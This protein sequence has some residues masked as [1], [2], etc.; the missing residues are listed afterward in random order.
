MKLR[1]GGSRARQIHARADGWHGY[2]ATWPAFF[3][4]WPAMAF[5]KYVLEEFRYCSQCP[6]SRVSSGVFELLVL[7]AVFEL[8]EHVWDL[9]LKL[10]R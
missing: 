5:S 1:E 7:F 2:Q 10:N 9:R 4:V 8:A 6:N 3:A